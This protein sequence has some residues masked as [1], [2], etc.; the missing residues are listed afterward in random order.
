[1]TRDLPPLLIEKIK[2]QNSQAFSQLY[3]RYAAPLYGMILHIVQD[4][5]VADDVLQESF[6]KIW[7][8]IS[9]WDEHRSSLFTW[10]YTIARNQSLDAW[11]RVSNRKI[12]PL[13]AS[14][15]SIKGESLDTIQD[16][17]EVLNLL[18][19]LDPKYRLVVDCLFIKGMSQREM[20]DETG[21]PLGTIKSRLA[22]ALSLLKQRYTEVI[23]ATFILS[24]V[25]HG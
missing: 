11:R 7:K 1:M 12:Q 24:I 25:S 17:S 2:Q 19:S 5:D 6:I 22:K 16:R 21:I 13:D 4:K 14:L 8:N 9:K 15:E 23:I 20:A 10:M 18:S 3:D